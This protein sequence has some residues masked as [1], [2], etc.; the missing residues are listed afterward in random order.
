[1]DTD[2]VMI[3][4]NTHW[5][6][7]GGLVICPSCLRGQPLSEAETAFQHE[8]DCKTGPSGDQKPWVS[9]HDIL[10]RVRG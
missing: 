6:L 1:M 4:W 5:T 8:H 3:E 9:L 2:Q 10:D 7:I